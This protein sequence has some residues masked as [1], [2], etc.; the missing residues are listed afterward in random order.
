MRYF[1]A[2]LIFASFVALSDSRPF[3]KVQSTAV[4]GSVS[5]GR[6]RFG[7]VRLELWDKDRT[8]PDDLMM[9]PV[10]ISYGDTSTLD[11]KEEEVTTIDPELRM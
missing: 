10:R 3:A 5:C 4:R 8:D 9:K 7:M 11:G 1:I 2:A 6:E